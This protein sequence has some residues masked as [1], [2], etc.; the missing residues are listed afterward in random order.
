LAGAAHA[1]LERQRACQ[2]EVEVAW[3][4]KQHGVTPQAS[5]S[6]VALLRQTL[7]AALVQVGERLAGVPQ[8]G[9]S[10]ETAPAAGPL[11]MAG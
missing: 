6:L 9:I 5:D 7:G 10:A 3:L 8:R 1:G 4:L 11:G 2:A